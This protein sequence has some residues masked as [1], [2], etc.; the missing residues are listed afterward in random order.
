[1]KITMPV[2]Q[3]VFFLRARL[4]APWSAAADEQGNSL[5]EMAI[6]VSL[7]LMLLI[8]IIETS[9]ALYTYNYVSDAAR[10]GSRWAIVRGSACSTN[11]PGLD[12]CNASTSEIQNYVQS[13]AYPG[14]NSSN[15][16]V[17]ATW[18]KPSSPPG[19]TWSSCVS[20]P[21]APCN[22]QGYEVQVTVSYPFPLNIPFWQNTNL[23]VSSTSSMVISQ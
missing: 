12:H 21:S 6:G 3:S 5:V 17:T 2:T 20:S 22:Q 7:F 4:R 10:E 23:T 13:L 9:L 8:G 11:T 1:M 18:L 16:T 19:A 14:I 15:L